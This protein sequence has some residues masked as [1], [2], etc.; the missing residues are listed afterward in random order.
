MFEP[1]LGFSG[2]LNDW[3][4][5]GGKDIRTRANEEVRRRLAAHQ[6][7]PLLPETEK[8]FARILKAAEKALL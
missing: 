8:E 6:D 3:D 4:D 7:A 1:K 5:M 2:L